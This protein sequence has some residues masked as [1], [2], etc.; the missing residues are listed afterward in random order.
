MSVIDLMSRL[1]PP[2]TDAASGAA[3]SVSDVFSA[4]S[5]SGAA[6]SGPTGDL[7]TMHDALAL[8]F[9]PGAWR[10]DPIFADRETPAADTEDAT[11]GTD[12]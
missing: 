4:S 1:N 8:E 2:S 10:N 12:R 3:F 9:D 11:D 6:S 7:F 5:S